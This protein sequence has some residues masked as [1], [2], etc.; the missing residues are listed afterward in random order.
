[1]RKLILATRNLDKVKE[2]KE[3]LGDLNLEILDLNNYSNIPEIVEDEETFE[4][5]AIKKAREVFK[6]VKLPVLSDDSG[7]EVEFLNNQP[8]IR[9]ARFAGEPTN[10]TKNNEKLLKML[11]NVPDEFRKAQFRCIVVFK[12]KNEE[13]LAEGICKGRI[14]RQMRGSGGFGYDPLFIPDGYEQTYAEMPQEVKNKISHRAIA[15]KNI[16]PFILEYFGKI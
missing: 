10:Y 3:I 6:I 16:K 13:I 1:M 11:D 8:G 5:N 2:I 4:D 14:L 7:L 9:S 15:L 12:T